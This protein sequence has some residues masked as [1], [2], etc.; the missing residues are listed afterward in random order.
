M[1]AVRNSLEPSAGSEGRGSLL[2]DSRLDDTMLL[3]GNPIP[4]TDE[5]ASPSNGWPD[6][7]FCTKGSPNRPP[8]EASV[9]AWSWDSCA[10][11]MGI[12]AVNI[13]RRYMI[14]MVTS[15]KNLRKTVKL[16]ARFS[17]IH[18]ALEKKYNQICG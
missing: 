4:V 11:A 14:K 8:A 9:S 13:R 7:P 10:M 2:C 3:L 1:S 15:K 17:I 18:R 6:T 16:W 12:I 5:A